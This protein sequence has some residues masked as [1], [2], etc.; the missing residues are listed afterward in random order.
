LAILDKFLFEPACL[1]AEKP[2]VGQ[3]TV[4]E[5][6]HMSIGFKS[7]HLRWVQHL[8]TDD[9]RQERKEH[10]RAVLPFLYAAQRDDWHHSVTDDESW[11]FFDL[12]PRRIWTLSRDDVATQPR[13]DIQSQN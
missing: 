9:L 12:S 2:P 11:F 3:A 5:H 1:I 10:S 13:L 6:L 4:L 8:L 7:F